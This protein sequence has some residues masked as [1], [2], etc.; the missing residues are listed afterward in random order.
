LSHVRS[1]LLAAVAAALAL[2]SPVAA[3]SPPVVVGYFASW[4]IY[5][6]G[7]FPKD[8]AADQLTHIN[9]AFAVPGSNGKCALRDPW[10]DYQVPFTATQSVDGAAD[11]AFQPLKGNFNQLRKLKAAHPGL[12]ILI[13]IGG[14]TESKYF[15]NAALTRASRRAFVRS[16]INMFFKGNLAVDN[17]ADGRGVANGIFDGVD[18]DWEFPV[19]CGYAGNIERPSDRLHVTALFKEFRRQL[20]ALTAATGR[21]YLLTAA[22]PS[23]PQQAAVS[24]DLAKVAS[25]LSWINVMTYDMHGSWDS[26]TAFNSP[27]SS[28]P[29]DPINPNSVQA[30]VDF[31]RN[32]GV[33]ASKLVVGVPFYGNQYIRVPNVSNGLYQPYDNSGLDGSSWQMSASVTYHD[34]VDVGQVVASGAT[35][36]GQS[37]FTRYWRAE[38]GE[39][40]LFAPSVNRGGQNVGVFITYE[41]PQSIA[42]RVAYIKSAGLRGAM[43]WELG[44]DDDAHDL[45]NALGALLTP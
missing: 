34:L 8:V 10:A 23:A 20:N 30:T 37:G 41:D 29:A 14:W 27:F 16:C 31:F 42:E 39:P 15:S 22:I 13:S 40:W 45:A 38:A 11:S 9:Y 3:A 12:K 24:Y 43:V 28:D 1:A 2:S 33:A 7:Y 36:V 19:C 4:D 17:G 25:L 21:P 18:I 44:S 35:P 32:H 26:Y 6:R 5:D